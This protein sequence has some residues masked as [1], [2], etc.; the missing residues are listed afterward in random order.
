MAKI[1]GKIG[2]LK[3]LKFE[4]ES[5]GINRFNSVKEINNFLANYNKEKQNILHDESEKLER[6]YTDRCTS[7][8][9]RKQERK[10]I[11]K[12]ETEKINSRIFELK[13][14]IDS[15]HARHEIS[16][17]RFISSIKLYFLK[18]KYNHYIQNK[19]SLVHS[20]VEAINER[21]VNDEV[22]ITSCDTSRQKMIHSRAKSKIEELQ[23]TRGVLEGLRNL[24]SGAIGENRVVNEIK[25]LSNDFVLINDF[26]H[27]FR[28]P[29][30]YKKQ[31]QRI[32]SIQID[33]LLIS[34][35]GIFIIETKNWSKSSVDSLS[36]RSPIEQL[37]R[38]SYA[39]YIFISENLSLPEH[40]WGEQRVPI[41]NLIV[42]IKNKPRVKFK[43]VRVK[44]PK[45]LNSYI[46]FFE[47]VLTEKQFN[48][49]VSALI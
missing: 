21:I 23:Y 20:S 33:H 43:Y 24:I 37:Q 5:S 36:L 28:R 46:N 25:K 16:L 48:S 35:A 27:R 3:A 44:L 1:Y 15:I 30:F 2:S 22:F 8:K 31:N 12:F 4:L 45:E 34:K 40:H 41:R 11:I 17:I 14:E 32:H 6:E 7:L 19:F 29:I 47:P 49:I 13:E 38:S 9:R 39:L 42:M 10:E 26:T 18:K